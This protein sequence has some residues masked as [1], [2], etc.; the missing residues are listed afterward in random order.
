MPTQVYANAQP[1]VTADVPIIGF[2]GPSAY[3]SSAG[4]HGLDRHVKQAHDD[5][6]R[7]L[8]ALRSR[9]ADVGA[10]AAAASRALAATTPPPERLLQDLTAVGAEFALL[11][12]AVLEEASV[13]PRPPAGSS[14]M[15]LRDLEAVTAA[16]IAAEEDRA[17]LAIWDVARENA[18][19]VLDRVL[20]VIHREDKDFPGLTECHARARELRAAVSGPAPADPVQQATTLDALLRPFSALVTLVEGWNRLDDERCAS[21]QDLVGRAFG[22]PL[23]LAALRGKLGHEGDTVAAAA[24]EPER[25]TAD[26]PARLFSAAAAT[27]AVAA[28]AAPVEAPIPA[29]AEPLIPA[30]V[31]APIPQPGAAP[32][33]VMPPAPPAMA[34]PPVLDVTPPPKFEEPWA[35]TPAAP[36]PPPPAQPELPAEVEIRL[37][38]DQVHVETPEERRERE[39]LLERL[40]SKSAQWWIRARTAYNALAKRDVSFANAVRETL[41]KYPFLLSVPLQ[42]SAEFAGGRLAEGYA[43]LL[44]RIEKEEAG[45]VET[46]LTRLN[47][48]F[49]TGGRTETYP[50]GQELYLY[51][52]AQG[53]LYKAFPEF[54]KDVLTLVLPTPGIWLQGSVTLSD[55]EALVVTNGAT[56]GSAVDDTRKMP[57][58]R[59]KGAEPTFSVTAGPLTTRVFAITADKLKQAPDVEIKLKENDTAS[60]KAWLVQLPMS[61]KPEAA[62]RHRA[63]GTAIEGLGKDYRGVLVAIFNSDPN[64]EKRYELAVTLKPKAALGKVDAGKQAAAKPSPFA[65]RRA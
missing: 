45:F 31:E 42:K 5:L 7:R 37:N 20:T 63:A 6:K 29:P 22:R 1:L 34:I 55:D 19:V 57:I 61:G 14:I 36:P 18:L 65:P 46:A 40:A 16:V 62:K 49:T 32:P 33:P 13:L 23:G 10:R 30:P 58:T 2:A 25:A 35:A 53:R 9:F 3:T 43:I 26:T 50:L 28:E 27:Q 4:D 41:E 44:Q 11:R 60:D 17:K 39:A 52:V 56:P 54:L 24:P 51:V 64:T 8:A 48:Q 12:A 38:T 47:P 15:R 59:E 21:L